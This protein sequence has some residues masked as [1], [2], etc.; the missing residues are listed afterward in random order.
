MDRKSCKIC[1]MGETQKERLFSPCR[2]S[3]TIKYIHKECLLSW[4]A[5]SRIS[6][7]DICQYEYRFKDVYRTDTPRMLPANVLVRGVVDIVYRVLGVAG[8]Y[9]VQI[10][11]WVGMFYVNGCLVLV[12]AGMWPTDFAAN[13]ICLAIGFPMTWLAKMHES[14]FGEICKRSGDVDRVA[15]VRMQERDEDGMEEMVDASVVREGSESAV[16]E[17]RRAVAP[18]AFLPAMYA[19]GRLV[20]VWIPGPLAQFLEDMHLRHIYTRLVAFGIVFWTCIQVLGHVHRRMHRRARHVLAFLRIYYIILLNLFFMYLT[21]GL[22]IHYMFTRMNGGYVLDLKGHGA[23]IRTCVSLGLHVSVGYISSMMIRNVCLKFKKCFR[24]G[25]LHFVPDDDESRIDELYEISKVG[26][27]GIFLRILGY[28]WMFAAFYGAGFLAIRHACGDLPRICVGNLFKLSLMCKMFSTVLYSNDLFSDYV[29]PGMNRMIRM[30]ARLLGLES[31]LYN[32][33][34]QGWGGR[35]VWSANRNRMFKRQHV[36][37]RERRTPTQDEIRRFFGKR[38]SADFSVFYVPGQLSLRCGCILASL[39]LLCYCFY[40]G[41][42]LTAKT[43][44]VHMRIE[45]F[46]PESEDMVFYFVL[47]LLLRMTWI[48]IHIV[49][50]VFEGRR[51]LDV[52]GCLLKH[53]IVNAYVNVLFPL[54]SSFTL[55]MLS[56]ETLSFGHLRPLRLFLLFFSNTFVVET[57]ICNYIL[58]SSPEHYSFRMLVRELYKFNS[59]ISVLFAAWYLYNAVTGVLGISNLEFV[60]VGVVV[61]HVVFIAR[62]VGQGIGG[63]K[64]FYQ[65]LLDENYLV[66]RRIINIDERD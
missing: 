1:H 33:P 19:A 26:L 52:A 35:M 56:G 63:N 18:V 58:R 11:K 55:I 39:V 14:L 62:R 22:A 44:V 9:G 7:C 40:A 37:A 59:L 50:G 46:F 45:E 6:R 65:R 8:W 57:M 4:M 16:S 27:S 2:C 54:F 15:G 3:G 23:V 29:V 28:L 61:G 30:Q 12:S 32:K 47:G 53:G 24:P 64:S 66:E 13:A 38:R 10:L 49:A 42:F 31:F 41:L 21:L 60:V 25:L 36:L 20:P 48:A 51:V 43:V 34:V 5:C 17:V